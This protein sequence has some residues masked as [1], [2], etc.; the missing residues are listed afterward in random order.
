M[1]TTTKQIAEIKKTNDVYVDMLI[2]SDVIEAKVTKKE[3]IHLVKHHNL[4]IRV[5]DGFINIGGLDEDESAI[6]YRS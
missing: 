4:Q 6:I 2:S 3:A 5:G 1:E